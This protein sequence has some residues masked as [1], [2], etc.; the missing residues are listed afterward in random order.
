VELFYDLD[1]WRRIRNMRA[2]QDTLGFVPTMGNLHVAHLALIN[3]SQAENIDTVV[4]LFVNQTQFNNEHDYIHY[5]RTLDADLELLEQADVRYCLLPNYKTMYPDD[6]RY[7][8]HETTNHLQLEGKQRAGHFSGVLTVVMKL[9]QLT[10]PTRAYFGE[11]DYEQ[12]RLIRD[13]VSAFF[14]DVDIVPCTT[15]RE[16]SGLAYSSRN[17]RLT[18]DGKK[19]A[20]QFAAIFH[21]AQ[22]CHD[23]IN[24]LL[25]LG[26]EVHYV[27][28]HD[29]RRF[30]AVSIDGVRLIDNYALNHAPTF[31]VPQ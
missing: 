9:L 21:Q 11:K 27:E 28:E 18:I 10:K 7:Q 12:Y 16:S 26:L 20:A 29:D 3:R 5:P 8:L 19:K 30:A 17:N 22:S 15:V 1:A 24:A 6:Y 23:T 25:A 13:M 31:L 14:M 2:P 4:S